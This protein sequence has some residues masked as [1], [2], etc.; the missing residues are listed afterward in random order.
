MDGIISTNATHCQMANG[1][2][3][4]MKLFLFLLASVVG[5]KGSR[6]ELHFV[7]GQLCMTLFRI[8]IAF[9]F[10]LRMLVSDQL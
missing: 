8:P 6:F 3:I 9:F 10:F 1:V 5:C 4:V 2:I 7:G